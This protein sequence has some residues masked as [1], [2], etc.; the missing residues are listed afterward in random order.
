MNKRTKIYTRVSEIY[1]NLWEGIKNIPEIL[2]FKFSTRTLDYIVSGTANI[3]YTIDGN[4][5]SNNILIRIECYKE[6]IPYYTFCIY[7]TQESELSKMHPVPVNDVGA[8][9][10]RILSMRIFNDCTKIV[11]SDCLNAE[12]INEYIKQLEDMINDYLKSH[13]CD[14]GENINLRLEAEKL[15]SL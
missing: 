8:Y 4:N 3:L 5:N 7:K 14:E 15:E 11:Y 1:E 13:G 12:D 10:D 2:D 9:Y 6:T